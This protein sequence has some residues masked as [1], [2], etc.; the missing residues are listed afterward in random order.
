MID[1]SIRNFFKYALLMFLNAG[2]VEM[3]KRR[4]TLGQTPSGRTGHRWAGPEQTE[5]KKSNCKAP[6]GADFI[7]NKVHLSFPTKTKRTV[8]PNDEKDGNKQVRDDN[9]NDNANDNLYNDDD[10]DNVDDDNTESKE[11]NHDMLTKRMGKT[12]MTIT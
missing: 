10:Y 1:G 2:E 12:M 7:E 3:V 4:T 11:L 6:D 8:L 5:K 9:D